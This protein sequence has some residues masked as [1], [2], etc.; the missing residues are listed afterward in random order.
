MNKPNRCL[1][2]L[3]LCI[4]LL[5][6]ATVFCI[7]NDNWAAI[8][9]GIGCGG[10]TSAAVAWL[11]DV[12]NCKTQNEKRKKLA[13]FALNDFRVALCEY[14]ETFADLCIDVDQKT[15][16]QKHVFEEWLKMYVSKLKGGLLVRRAWLVDAI[17]KVNDS[18][19]VF[20]RNIYWLIDGE[21][22]SVDEYKEIKMLR[23]AIHSSEIYYRIK[24]KEPNPDVILEENTQ[25]I[26]QTKLI[27]S[28]SGILSI[29]YAG[30]GDL[31]NQLNSVNEFEFLQ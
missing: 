8:M 17:E 22:I 10:V 20:E 7:H 31:S 5:I 28:L 30:D 19:A 15:E 6:T 1:Y 24:D 21:V 12:A 13:D 2:I 4:S 27:N 23:E 14:F 11:I 25:I 18:Y 9:A 3:I 26:A 16:G 29:A